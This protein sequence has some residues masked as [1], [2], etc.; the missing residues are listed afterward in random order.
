MII[1]IPSIVFH[2]LLYIIPFIKCVFPYFII[3]YSIS[4]FIQVKVKYLP[5]VA[6]RMY[7]YTQESAG[8]SPVRRILT[9]YVILLFRYLL[10]PVIPFT[11]TASAYLFFT[12]FLSR[13]TGVQLHAWQ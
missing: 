7:C 9:L 5:L 8:H 3:Y 11:V 10:F 6:F 12:Y 1:Y 13:Y 2:I 4:S